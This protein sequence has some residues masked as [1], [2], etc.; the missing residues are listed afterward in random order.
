MV[1]RKPVSVVFDAIVNP[2]VTTKFW[3]TKSSGKLMLG[4]KLDWHWDMYGLVVPL[5]V[6]ELEKN[7]KVTILWGTG[8]QES[9]VN[10]GF[11]SL[12]KDTTFVE[13]ENYG[14]KG[15]KEEV[16]AKV[17]DSTGGFNLMLAGMKCWLEH[18]VALNLAAD[19]M[20]S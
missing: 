16:I 5:E 17:V 12:S 7:L 3:F 20:P 10:F 9:E 19:K 8:E 2:E 11:H 18:G 4:K 6:K 15:S 14:F 13:I 1:I